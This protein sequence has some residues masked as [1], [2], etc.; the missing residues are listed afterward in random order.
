MR[1]GDRCGSVVNLS[2]DTCGMASL[3]RRHNM[4]VF[5]AFPRDFL[6]GAA[7][8]SYQVEGAASEDGR[9]PSV[10]DTFCRRRGAIARDQTGDRSVDQYHR[11]KEDVAL[12]KS[13]GIKAYRFS[14]SWSRVAPNGR[15]SI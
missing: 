13:L 6:W 9:T 10:W 14:S 3:A 11:Y 4:A 7:T 2:Y 8:A 15:G 1:L 12:M 5:G